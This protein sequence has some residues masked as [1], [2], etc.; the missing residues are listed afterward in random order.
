MLTLVYIDR[1]VLK[2]F[3]L[4]IAPHSKLIN[5]LVD[6]SNFVYDLVG[7]PSIQ[8]RFS[9]TGLLIKPIIFLVRDYSTVCVLICLL[10]IIGWQISQKQFRFKSSAFFGVVNIIVVSLTL[11]IVGK[12]PA[13]YSWM[14][15]IPTTISLLMTLDKFL[16]KHYNYH[17]ILTDKITKTIIIFNLILLIFASSG[18]FTRIFFK[19]ERGDYSKAEKFV[20]KNVTKDDVVFC[21]EQAYYPAKIH[22]KKIFLPPYLRVI[23]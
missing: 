1:G 23:S 19:W 4:S 16:N 17:N 20:I 11:S 22:A 3:L 6:N 2:Y 10:T 21:D 8:D 13:Y 12:I 5:N 9:I 14:I 15:F 18:M 7:D